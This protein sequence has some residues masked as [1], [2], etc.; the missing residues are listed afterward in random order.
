MKKA[1]HGHKEGKM[2]RG[3]PLESGSVSKGKKEEK[4]AI[5]SHERRR[6][7]PPA[8]SDREDITK[9]TGCCVQQIS[10][11]THNRKSLL[12]GE[13]FPHTLDLFLPP[14]GIFSSIH[15]KRGRKW[16]RTYTYTCPK[17]KSRQMTWGEDTCS[18][19][20]HSLSSKGRRNSSEFL[21][22]Q[23]P[24]KWEMRQRKQ[25]KL[26]EENSELTVCRHLSGH[27][28]W[29]FISF[30]AHFDAYSS[31]IIPSLQI[32]STGVI[33]ERF[34]SLWSDQRRS[35]LLSLG[36]GSSKKNFPSPQ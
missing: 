19:C 9:E 28:Y 34:F 23:S 1:Q 25:R 15:R 29:S 10:L 32:S 12:E 26:T 35:L 30:F 21:R 18:V 11:A 6:W 31:N 8:D 27:V 4:I 17:V 7:R 24:P 2:K 3:G 16:W 13:R 36:S 22:K 14:Q 20:G 33:W 5:Q